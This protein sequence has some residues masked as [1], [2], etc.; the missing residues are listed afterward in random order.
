[1]ITNPI[2]VCNFYLLVYEKPEDAF[3][4]R[5]SSTKP[6]G[7]RNEI[8]Y[9]LRCYTANEGRKGFYCNPNEPIFVI[10]K[11]DRYGNGPEHQYWN[12]VVGEKFGWIAV[13]TWI[14]MTELKNATI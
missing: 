12:V 3:K 10:E 5:L 14:T 9:W 4:V 6:A 2:Y 8:D 13:P 11:T 1:M 7:F